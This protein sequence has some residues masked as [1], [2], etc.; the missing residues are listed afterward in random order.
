M[1]NTKINTELTILFSFLKEIISWRVSNQDGDI[2]SEA[3]KLSLKGLGQ[4]ATTKFIKKSSCRISKLL[5][6]Y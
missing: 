2:N 3:P 5:F 4:S 6:F 1:A